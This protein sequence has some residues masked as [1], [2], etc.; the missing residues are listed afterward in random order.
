M[1]LQADY[2]KRTKLRLT[3]YLLPIT[4]DHQIVYI[5]FEFRDVRRQVNGRNYMFL[6][7]MKHRMFVF[8]FYFILFHLLL[9]MPK[10]V[11]IAW[12][13]TDRHFS[14]FAFLQDTLHLFFWQKIF[15]YNWNSIQKS[16]IFCCLFN[17][18]LKSRARALFD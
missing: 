15:S 16:R 3:L 13:Q 5:S 6:L 10:F 8:L 9:L 7:T 17:W 18:M 1:I 12:T 4:W 14:L 2:S 11:G